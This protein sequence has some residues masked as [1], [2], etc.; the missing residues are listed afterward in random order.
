MQDYKSRRRNLLIRA[1]WQVQDRL[2]A[3]IERK[4]AIKVV[5]VKPLG[6]VSV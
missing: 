1:L 5:K 3:R 6:L 4:R 2:D